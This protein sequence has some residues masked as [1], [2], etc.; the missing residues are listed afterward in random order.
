MTEGE[1]AILN[2]ILG[3][4]SYAHLSMLKETFSTW[5]KQK[6]GTVS[7]D[8]LEH[9]AIAAFINVYTDETTK[10]WYFI[11]TSSNQDIE[12]KIKKIMDKYHNSLQTRGYAIPPSLLYSPELIRSVYW[13]TNQDLIAIFQRY[14][15][16]PGAAVFR[17]YE[18]PSIVRDNATQIEQ[19][20]QRIQDHSKLSLDKLTD[21]V[22][23]MQRRIR[24]KLR[25]REEVRRI[26]ARE[27]WEDYVQKMPAEQLIQ[28]ASTPYFPRCEDRAL[29][30]RIRRIAEQV[31]LYS[32]VKHWTSTKHIASIFNDALYGRRQLLQTY[33]PFD[34]ACLNGTDTEEGDGPVICFGPSEID[35]KAIQP[36]GTIEL[37]FDLDKISAN[38]QSIFYK[39]CDFGF[40]SDKIRSVAMRPDQSKFLFFSHTAIGRDK[41]PG[42]SHL[43]VYDSKFIKKAKASLPNFALISYNLKDIHQILTLNF[44][45][46]IDVNDEMQE[47]FIPIKNE[48]YADLANLS[49]AQLLQFLINIGQ[50][51]SDTSEFNFYG[52]HRIDFSTL[53]VI[54]YY[55]NQYV[56]PYTLDLSEL[57]QSLNQNDL[58]VLELAKA[59]I[60]NIFN[61]YRFLDYLL[62]RT[63]AGLGHAA[64]QHLRS[65]C[66]GLSESTN[67][68]SRGAVAEV[69]Q[70]EQVELCGTYTA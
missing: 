63:N 30:L 6:L 29:A 31:R 69:S 59:K 10:F 13:S 51:L 7:Q 35:P 23:K 20:I 47:G 56:P 61:S 39:Q 41:T 48:I 16:I 49:D 11:Q 33:V 55:E 15:P 45:R 8:F 66:E 40:A 34:P 65:Q 38:N 9:P 67:L 27:V 18:V 4:Q 50:Q 57:I 46:F 25:H 60:P 64:L 70:S 1:R 58:S 14:L 5:Q 37:V 54:K 28:D 32:T 3:P 12:K 17:G 2:T 53:N 24:G 68:S 22:V 43:R 42:Y 19:S 52:S 62:S 44:F 26:S 21:M 36:A